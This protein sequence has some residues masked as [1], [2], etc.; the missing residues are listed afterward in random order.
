MAA[1][2]GAGAAGGGRPPSSFPLPRLAFASELATAA[3][4]SEGVV[5]SPRPRPRSAPRSSPSA[6]AVAA[7]CG[8]V[9]LGVD[10]GA[11][12]DSLID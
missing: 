7:A 4:S 2:A 8:D 9:G 10:G 6:A 5:A 11:A 12:V 3:V 1:A